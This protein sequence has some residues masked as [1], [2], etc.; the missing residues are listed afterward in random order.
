MKAFRIT[1]VLIVLLLLVLLAGGCRDGSA[2]MDAPEIAVTNSYLEAVVRDL[3][4]P[5][6]RILS[7][8]PPGMCPGHFDISPAQV[9]RLGQCRMLLLFDFQQKVETTLARLKANGLATHLVTG[10][11]GLCVPDVY[12]ATCREVGALLSAAYPARATEF[13]G[14]IEAIERRLGGLG[15]EL[16]ASVQAVGGTT[17]KVLASN[18]QVKFAQWLGLEVVAT[19]VGSDVETISNIDH[20]LRQAAGHEIRFVI[21]NQQEGTALAGALADRLGARAVVFS[22]FPSQAD[23]AMG[24][25]RLLRDNV[26][27]LIETVAP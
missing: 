7:L 5:D 12:L 15:D 17:A 18:H 4:G 20:C 3:C 6:T 8:A 2:A 25:D 1:D 27:G 13:E 24:F 9:R 10:R 22:N 21:A 19:F 11:A 23:D 16:G 26:R 14:R